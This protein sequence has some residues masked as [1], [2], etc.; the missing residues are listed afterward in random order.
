MNAVSEQPEGEANLGIVF[1]PLTRVFE[2][3]AQNTVWPSEFCKLLVEDTTN[4]I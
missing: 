2:N 4:G 3:G 1:K